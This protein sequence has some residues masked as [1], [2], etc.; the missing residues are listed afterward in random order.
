VSL[1]V[2]FSGSL[3]RCLEATELAHPNIL[4]GTIILKMV[5][6]WLKSDQYER[7]YGSSGK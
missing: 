1:A 5:K 7:R 2:I 4:T 6:E 3:L